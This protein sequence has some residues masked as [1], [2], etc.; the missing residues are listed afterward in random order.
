MLD[1]RKGVF[2]V[3]DDDHSANGLGSFLVEDASPQGWSVRYVGHILHSDRSAI[4]GGYYGAFNI[5]YLLYKAH[6]PYDIFNTVYLYCPSPYIKVG[7]LYS[8][9]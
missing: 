5:R 6:A 4:P 8:A 3:P 2:P 9:H 7:H 1:G